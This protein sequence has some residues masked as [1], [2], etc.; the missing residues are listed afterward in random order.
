MLDGVHRQAGEGLGVCVAVVEAVDEAVDGTDVHEAVRDVGVQVPPERH[1]QHPQHV[2]RD[3]A[4]AAEDLGQGWGGRA[5]VRVGAR[6][7]ARARLRV[8]VRVRVGGWGGRAR[9]SVQGARLGLRLM[10]TSA[11]DA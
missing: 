9:I 6:V 1:E 10:R 2:P 11:S 4:G 7:G 5:R 8:G 3:E